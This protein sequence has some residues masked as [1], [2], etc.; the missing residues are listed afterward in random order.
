VNYEVIKISLIGS[1]AIS[2]NLSTALPPTK[3]LLDIQTYATTTEEVDDSLSQNLRTTTASSPVYRTF[4]M[5]RNSS[6]RESFMYSV[7]N[8]TTIFDTAEEEQEQ[9]CERK[10]SRKEVHF[11]PDGIF[12]YSGEYFL[13]TEF[14]VQS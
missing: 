11:T 4:P 7:E 1:D 8:I 10:L 3:P 2:I 12:F 13:P 6:Y 5:S 9:K 14:C